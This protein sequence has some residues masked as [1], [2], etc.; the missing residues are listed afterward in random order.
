MRPLA[1]HEEI[2]IAKYLVSCIVGL[3]EL[4]ESHLAAQ[5]LGTG[6]ACVKTVCSDQTGSTLYKPRVCTYHSLTSVLLQ[7]VIEKLL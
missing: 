1:L 7:Q 3:R 6:I 5:L 4:P 2:H